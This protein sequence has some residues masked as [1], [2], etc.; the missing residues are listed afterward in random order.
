MTKQRLTV[1]TQRD[2]ASDQDSKESTIICRC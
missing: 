1:S 2:S